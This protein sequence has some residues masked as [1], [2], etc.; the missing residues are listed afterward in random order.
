MFWTADLRVTASTR[1]VGVMIGAPS[2]PVVVRR[3]VG[4]I[5]G[6]AFFVLSTQEVELAKKAPRER[7]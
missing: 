2:R 3:R 5:A 4:R 6:G 7:G 1:I